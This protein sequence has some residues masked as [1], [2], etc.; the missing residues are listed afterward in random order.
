M[1]SVSL[2]AT[3]LNDRPSLIPSI[4]KNPNHK[5]KENTGSILLRLRF[6]SGLQVAAKHEGSGASRLD[7]QLTQILTNGNPLS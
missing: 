7:K 4:S 5:C 1:P 3:P 2:S 6:A